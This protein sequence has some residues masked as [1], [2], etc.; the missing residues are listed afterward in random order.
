LI[1]ARLLAITGFPKEV[2]RIGSDGPLILGRDLSNQVVVTDPAVSRKHCSVSEISSGVFE[3][4]DL[5]S[6]HGTFVNE[7]QVTRQTL[8]HGDRI[9]IGSSEFVFLTDP[10][11]DAALLTSRRGSA[12]AIAE[13]GCSAS[14]P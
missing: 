2:V 1:N 6:H 7:T 14:M 13:R 10:E 9:R 3:I 11:D 8:Q 4:A 12:G 5:D